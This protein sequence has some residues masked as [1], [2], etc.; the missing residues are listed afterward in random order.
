MVRAL[1]PRRVMTQARAVPIADDIDHLL[2][3]PECHAEALATD[4]DGILYCASC[5]SR[6]RTDPE[7]GVA[8]LI[9]AASETGDKS[10]IMDWWADLFRQVYADHAEL[11]GATLA[12]LLDATEELFAWREMLAV[13]E[14]PFDALDGKLVLEI[15]SGSGAHSALFARRG[16]SVVAVDITPERVAATARM[17]SL[18]PGEGRAYQ[19][20]AENL[21][22][23]DDA[24]DIVYSNGVLHHSVDTERAVAEVRRV[25]KPG[26]QAVIML[27]ARHS[28]TY[29]LNIVPRGLFTG[30]L[31]RW[32]EAEWIGRMTEGKPRFG[33][34]ANPYTRVYSKRAIHD[35]FHGFDVL[36][37]RRN[38][39]QF[40]NFCFPRLTQ[41][42]RRVL[43]ALGHPPHP[44]A[45]LVYG[46]GFV[47]ETRLELAL[48]RHIGFGWNIVAAKPDVDGGSIQS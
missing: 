25:L 23:R 3:C 34:T 24:F 16:A 33:A 4:D 9:A 14:M 8:S 36:G 11:D 6:Y 30:A 5:L 17:L 45:R 15:G 40:D 12:T 37:L 41:I 29:W 32:P 27:Y 42:R 21:P 10:R 7:H 19:A 48:G 26:G 39:F 38:S 13:V 22:F 46:R 2:R 1:G 20:D 43:M 44:G 18:V 47:P 31:F 28:A 35:L